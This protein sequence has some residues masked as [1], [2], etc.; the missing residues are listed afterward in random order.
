MHCQGV[1]LHGQA[2]KVCASVQARKRQRATSIL[3]AADRAAEAAEGTPLLHATLSAVTVT[4]GT[5]PAAALQLHNRGDAPAAFLLAPTEV[6]RLYY[7]CFAFCAFS[8]SPFFPMIFCLILSCC[9]CVSSHLISS[10]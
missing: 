2:V 4:A 7:R 10:G 3:A 5:A 1:N 9:W 6:Q 8:S